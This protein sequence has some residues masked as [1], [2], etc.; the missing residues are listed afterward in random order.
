ML[1]TF[2]R[3]RADASMPPVVILAGGL[4]TR[5][6]EETALRPKPMIEIGGHPM[7]WHIMKYFGHYGVNE[8]YVALGYKGEVVKRFFLDYFTLNGSMSIELSTGQLKRHEGACEDWTVHLIDTGPDTDTG[9][10][11]KRLQSRLGDR[12]FILTYGDG[13]CSVD[14]TDLLRFHRAHG[15]T[16]TV[17]A[18]RPPS[19]FGGLEID[20]EKVVTFSEKPQIGEGWINGGFMVLEPDIFNYLTGDDDSLESDA[21][22][23]LARD[24]RLA[25]YRHPSFWQCMDTLR[26]KRL[27]ER[28]WEEG[29]APWKVWA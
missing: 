6:S 7:L 20:G 9:G 1:H 3:S 21:L 19:R 22:E 13:V 4:G 26:D 25:A 11:L 2:G 8:F 17:T 5:I 14:P 24:G 10:R 12:T 18:V 23:R 28:M 15:M 29:A 27:L 16:A